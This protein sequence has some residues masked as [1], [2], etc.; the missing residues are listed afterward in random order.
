MNKNRENCIAFQGEPGAYSHM[1]C[2][3]VCPDMTALPC[4]GFEDV[5]EAITDGRAR[6]AMIPIENSTAG[7][8]ADIHF[9][10]PDSG[11]FIIA[12]HFQPVRHCLLAPGGVALT[13]ITTVYSH[14]QALSQCHRTIRKL[15]LTP[16][17]VADTAGSARIVANRGDSRAASIAS[18]LA[19]EIYGLKIL[20][21]GLQD[22]D[23]NMTR[24]V[25][26][27]KVPNDPD[28]LKGPLMTTFTFE[29]KNIPAALYKALG[30]FATNGVNMTKLESYQSGASFLATT[31]FADIEGAPGEENVARAMEELG[32]HTKRV[33]ILGTYPQ[34]R[35][36][37]V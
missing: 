1:A 5:F 20:R 29:V 37:G 31:F 17:A 28:T 36:R 24:F 15:G 16:H 26:L 8:V 35:I 12:E 21:R 13:D 14:I 32:F 6:L 25:V 33:D 22:M 9:L 23:H 2:Q 18:E 10:L 30:G 3:A 4:P 34:T 27:S 11:L 7:R 19:A